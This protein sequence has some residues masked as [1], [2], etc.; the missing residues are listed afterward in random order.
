MTLSPR[1]RRMRLVALVLL[2][3]AGTVNYLDR[4]AL[5]IGNG[6][7]RADLHLS[8]IQMGLL[9]SAF[10]LAYGVA[11][12]PIG[13]LIDRFGPRRILGGG[14]VLWSVAQVGSGFVGGLG[15]FIAA[16]AALGI[17]ESPMYLAG[18][19]V[20]TNWYP[21]AERSWPIGI[22]NAS[23]ALGPT[24]APALLT[25]LLLTYGWRP[26]FIVIGVGGIAIALLWEWL[27]RDPAEAGLAPDE[28]ATIRAWDDDSSHAHAKEGWPALFRQRTTW[29][30]AIGFFGVIY[31][32]WLYGTWLPDYLERERHLSVKAAGLWTAVP[33]AC[34]F[35]GAILGG[36]ASRIL[37]RRG[38]APV[39][40][41]KLPLIAG[42][43]VTA[44][45]TA[46][47]ALV[48]DAGAAIVLIS[49]ALFS[50]TL[51]SSCG[52]AMAAV[53]T[54]PDK[55]ATLEAIQNIGGS[56]GGA[57]APAITGGVVWATGSFTPALLFA[58]AIAVL[59]AIV[60]GLMVG[61]PAGKR[62][63]HS[64]EGITP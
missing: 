30:M 56:L 38:V 1:A 34:G 49:L 10:E 63:N 33:Q 20:F 14:L 53:A 28:L 48:H 32:T 29:G 64:A 50:A 8:D 45:C 39:A 12:L 61:E 41:C 18:T 31:L 25:L 62:S 57:C 60:Y 54:S 13:V 3:I 36:L 4:S 2:V 59:S 52:W 15:Q 42:M 6:A 9:L 40:S 21:P 5:S 22:F 26:M 19:K 43:L 47:A 55:V 7:I 27:Y 11:Q 24:I 58:S 16:R 46:G 51:A 23:S 17:G 44:A 37:S 35:L